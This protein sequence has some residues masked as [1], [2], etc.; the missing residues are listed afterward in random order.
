MIALE[1]RLL[2]ALVRGVVPSL[3]S[4]DP[5]RLRAVAQY[6]R[7]APLVLKRW[8]DARE[9]PVAAVVE[10]LRP[11]A[12]ADAARDMR[13]VAA[14]Q[15]ALAA[16]ADADV[17]CLVLKGAAFG[18]LLYGSTE[19]R[20]RLDVDVWVDGWDAAESVADRLRSHRFHRAHQLPGQLARHAVSMVRSPGD[21]VDVHARPSRRFRVSAAL[22]FDEAWR[23]ATSVTVHG[24]QATTLCPRDAL[25][26]AGLH[27]ASHHAAHTVPWIHLEDLARLSSRIGPED[28]ETLGD[29][30]KRHELASAFL[31]VLGE[32]ARWA[33]GAVPSY[34]EDSL[35]EAAPDASARFSRELSAV[36]DDLTMLPPAAAASYLGE[37]AFPPADYLH[38]HFGTAHDRPTPLLWG[39]RLAKGLSNRLRG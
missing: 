36:A 23:D 19:L 27:L 6:H 32:L 8:A 18:P 24:L 5:D 31:T 38:R 10:I 25:L 7:I 22:D 26:H 3:S 37:L 33:P 28:W 30:L 1:E 9:D 2:R 14:L 29:Q 11:V 34:F 20:P 21:A 15:Q 16:C 13:Q 35:R 17:R 39:W 12:A 4:F